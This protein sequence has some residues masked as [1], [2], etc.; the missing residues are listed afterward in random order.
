MDA[1][2]EAVKTLEEAQRV[3]T[4]YEAE[5]KALRGDVLDV[6]AR[7]AKSHYDL[8][9]AENSMATQHEALN[10]L[11]GRDVAT[12]FRVDFIP[13]QDTSDLTL[14][15]ARHEA[16]ANVPKIGKHILKKSKRSMTG[17]SR[18]LNIFRT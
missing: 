8:S 15:S 2:L 3:T 6:E 17:V 16:L 13:E 4:Q 5:K 14:D 1:A 10:Q 9:V 12:P 7:L 18:R 11:L